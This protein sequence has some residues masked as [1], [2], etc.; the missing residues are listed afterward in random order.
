MRGS[1]PGHLLW[2]LAV[3]N[4]RSEKIRQLTSMATAMVAARVASFM[5]LVGD[6]PKASSKTFTETPRNPAAAIPPRSGI[7]TF[8]ALLEELDR[9]GELVQ[10]LMGQLPQRIYVFARKLL[11]RR[12]RQHPDQG[13]A[14][15]TCIAHE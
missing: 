5:N 12:R 6:G 14:Q 10:Q 13:V 15:G 7:R 11:A 4:R 2:T 9:L 1:C 8:V 3:R